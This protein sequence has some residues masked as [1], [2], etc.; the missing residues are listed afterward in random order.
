[1]LVL[2]CFSVAAFAQTAEE[3]VAKNLEAKGGPDKINALK[4][5]R[6]S[7]RFQDNG[8]FTAEV[9]FEMKAPDAIRETFSL[10]GMTQIQAYDGKTGWQIN[11]FNGRKD[12]ELMGE[13]DLRG[14]V[15]DAE[16]FLHGALADAAAKG[17]KIE[18]MGHATVDGDDAYKLK[19]TLKNGDIF[20]YYLDPDTYLE[21]HVERQQFIRGAVR[22]QFTDL[23]S[24]KQVN[25]VYYPFTIAQAERRDMSDVSTITLA[26]VEGNAPLSDSDFAMPAGPKAASPQHGEPANPQASKEK[27]KA[28]A[29]SKPPASKPPQQ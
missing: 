5:V 2:L 22:E 21:F 14:V 17:S 24:Y 15:E 4:T 19:V 12:P 8:G 3:L 9:T 7:G 16:L 26:K 23:G 11:P 27:A 28:P 6:A 1:M 25:G 20:Y 10:Q 13:E 18:Y 29:K